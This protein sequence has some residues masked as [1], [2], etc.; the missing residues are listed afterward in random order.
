[1]YGQTKKELKLLNNNVFWWGFEN[2]APALQNLER[3]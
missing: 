3:T 2:I 1:M